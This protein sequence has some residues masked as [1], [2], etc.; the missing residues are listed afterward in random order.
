[1]LGLLVLVPALAWVVLTQPVLTGPSHMCGGVGIDPGR[2]R[3]HVT[4]IADPA[5]PRDYTHPRTLDAIA[6]YIAQEFQN[7]G[8]EVS[9][10]SYLVAGVPYRNVVAAFGPQA[11]EHI[12]IGAHYDVAGL[13][14]GADDN[15]SGVAGLLDLAR[16]LGR[17]PFPA[18]VQLVAY[19]LEEPPFFRTGHM[20]S[21]VHA[22]SL[23]ESGARVRAMISLEMIGYF[24]DG[25]ETQQFP[26]GFL[27][28]L[29]PRTGDF[30]AV[31]GK[32]GQWG[33]VRTI[34]QAMLSASDLPV[35]S[36]NAPAWV[37][38][39]DFSDHLSYW[40]AGY[41]AVMITDTA[42]YRNDRY[43]TP[44]DTADSLDYERMAKVVQGVYCAIRVLSRT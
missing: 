37:T 25:P 4:R 21:A 44:R 27:R 18:R 30:I 41:P 20:G 17:T 35:H 24:T 31:V 29:Y 32:L 23:R 42:F 1:M 33:T 28:Y 34:K 10:Q 16:A 14:P 38:G 39:I 22:R 43:H 9:E 2:L 11:G 5:S 7:A 6:D 15:A 36:I 8:A 12:I 40:L 3:S 19:A 13:Q 26:F